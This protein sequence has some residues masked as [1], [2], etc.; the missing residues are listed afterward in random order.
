MTEG[1]ITYVYMLDI[2]WIVITLIRLRK[3]STRNNF[4]KMTDEPIE[5]HIGMEGGQP[6]KMLNENKIKQPEQLTMEN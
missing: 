4:K 1:N 5:Q 6:L 2:L 3:R